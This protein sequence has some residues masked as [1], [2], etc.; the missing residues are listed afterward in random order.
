MHVPEATGIVET[1]EVAA[2]LVAVLGA[3]WD[4]RTRR[5]PNILTFG[6]AVVALTVHL[7]AG[8]WWGLLWA[9][10]GW[11][12]GLAV[13]LPLF[14][15]GGLG[16]GDV[17]LL[18]ALGAWLGPA[19]ALWT[20]LYGAIAG[21]L[22]AVLIALWQGYLR[23]ALRNLRMLLSYWSVMGVRPLPELTLKTGAGPR[24]P[25]AMAIGAGVL[26]AVWLH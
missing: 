7:L 14:L 17:K 22:M 13:F 15:L 9:A 3:A 25:Y 10:G 19:G 24:L 8:G 4:L 2:L 16:A 5:V 21:G 12:T 20:A 26:L 23:T 1:F 11:M 6:A 18:A